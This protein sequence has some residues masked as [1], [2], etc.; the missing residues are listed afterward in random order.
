M[1]ESDAKDDGNVKA[2]ADDGLKEK[3][4]TASLRLAKLEARLVL[5]ERKASEGR[6]VTAR[7]LAHKVT[8]LGSRHQVE[9][10][11]LLDVYTMYTT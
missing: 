10:V 3:L 4:R 5:S 7:I 8:R 1:K 11:D 9:A 6:K 2:K